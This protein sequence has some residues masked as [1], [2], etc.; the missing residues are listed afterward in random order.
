MVKK[1]EAREKVKKLVKEFSEYSKEELDKK[2]ENQ[3]K[4]EFIDPLFEALGWD[5][6]K[7]AERESRILK[8]RADYIL[9]VENQER[10]VIEAKKV[11]VR[12]SEEKEGMQTVSYAHHQKIKFAVLTNFKQIRVYHALSQTARI[13][14]NLLQD[15]TGLLWIN[16]EDFIKEFDRLWILSKES[17][18]KEEIDKLLKNVDKK[19]IKPI[20]ESILESLLEIRKL[21]SSDLKN[22]RTYLQSEQIDEAVQIFIV[23]LI[24]MRSV[25]DRGLEAK[26]FLLKIKD[27]VQG[28]FAEKNLWALLKEQ[29]VR[30]DKTYNSKL[31][32]EGLLE[33]ND[34]FFD[35]LT[36]KKV[37]NDVYYGTTDTQFKYEFD[38]IPSDLLGS[39]YEQYLGTILKGTEKRVR[40]DE[41]SGKRK[42]MGIYYTPSYIVD[43]I[44]KNTVGEYIKDKTIDEILNV[45]IVDPACGS[46]SFLIRAFQEVCDTVENRL[47]KGEKVKHPTFKNYEGRLNLAQKNTIALRCIYGVD[48]DEKAIELAELNILLKILEGETRDT[49]KL[50]LENLKGNIKNG[51]SLI[52]DSKVAGDKAF[53]WNAQFPDVFG[54]GGFDVVIGNPPYIDSEEMVKTQPEVREY[55]SSHYK[56]AKGN[57]DIFGVFI[58]MGLNL[59]KE[60]GIFGEIIPNKLLSAKYTGALREFIENKK[61]IVSIRD[62]SKI[63]VFQ[64]SV[65]PIVIIIK[66]RFWG[67]NKIL[68]ETMESYGEDVR[69]KNSNVI[70]QRD[71]I[72]S[73]E[74]TWAYTFEKEGRGQLDKILENS[75][76]LDKLAKINGSATVSEAYEIKKKLRNLSVD[77]DYFKFVNTG[78]I[79][80][81][82][83]LWKNYKTQYI[84]GSYLKPII[85]KKDLEKLFPKRAIESSNAKII[86]AGMTKILECAV[87]ENGEYLAGKSTTLVIPDKINIKILLAILNSGLMTYIYKNLFKSL[88]LS[89]G[90]MNVGPQ[91]IKNLP[92]RLPSISQEKIIISL[93]NEMIELQKKLHEKN[94]VGYEKE[95]LERQIKNIDY[96]INQEVYKLYGLTKE[97]IEIVE[98]SLK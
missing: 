8:G 40:L 1:E 49:K 39:I 80:R 73:S 63:S 22:R 12:L 93:V 51:N 83:T 19:I 9:K 58:E 13:D 7:D 43:Y 3:I 32:S 47:K 44:V 62:Y 6:R 46:G 25:E 59:L 77:K 60:N 28:G 35:D 64:A 54:N 16:Y 90:Y 27:S 74:K 33:K 86:I 24:F 15:N 70:N 84:K 98:E 97:E 2:S 68:T 85:L 14:K 23:R 41:G 50:L 81:Y 67:E 55:C 48:L 71:L 38:L 87:D 94:L 45:R 76:A 10:L 21:L 92:I 72:K 17:F 96:E 61:Q 52:D 95:N 42:K 88:A 78:T 65:Y 66:N 57:W 82:V 31:F 79:D 75:V 53:N 30:F 18:E 91:Q 20:D 11:S 26:D 4:S 89:G 36:L 34:V 56:T 37:I 69:I 5:M 29:F